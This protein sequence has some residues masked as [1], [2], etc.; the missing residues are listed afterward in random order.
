MNWPFLCQKLWGRRKREKGLNWS[1]KWDFNF[2]E[3][4]I[5]LRMCARGS[6]GAGGRRGRV[7]GRVKDERTGKKEYYIP[8]V[9]EG[10][11]KS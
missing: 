9:K 3:I 8:R 4:P 7:G 1:Q 10:E 5:C 2:L 6:G 11:V